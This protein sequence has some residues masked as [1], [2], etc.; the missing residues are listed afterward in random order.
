MTRLL[1]D[2]T[3]KLDRIKYIGADE[4]GDKLIADQRG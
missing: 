2:H 3:L 1:V 4:I